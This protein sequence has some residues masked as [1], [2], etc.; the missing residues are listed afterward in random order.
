MNKSK[1][2]LLRE[3]RQKKISVEVALKNLQYPTQDRSLVDSDNLKASIVS[4]AANSHENT[5]DWQSYLRND[6]L[7]LVAKILKLKPEEIN[8][9]TSI[10]DLGL[11]SLSATEFNNLMQNQ[12]KIKISPTIFFECNTIDDFQSYLINRHSSQFQAYYQDEID[13]SVSPKIAE[14][15]F[16]KQSTATD[17]EQNHNFLSNK[18]SSYLE[19]IWAELE[20]NYSE[21]KTAKVGVDFARSHN[22]KRLVI[23][24]PD[25]LAIEV[26]VSSGRGEPL[27]LL[28]GL[29]NSEEIWSNQLEMLQENYQV[30]IFNKPGC[31]RS[32]INME[33]L[34]LDMI[35]HNILTVLDTLNIKSDLTVI[36]YSFGGILAQLLC[37]KYPQKV[38]SLIIACS[39]PYASKNRTE[40]SSLIEE[41]SNNQQFQEIFSN[42]DLKNL[43]PYYQI[44]N[45]FN[46]WADLE[47]ITVPTLILA[48]Q[49]D[50]YM[51]PVYSEAINQAIPQS[52]YQEIE[53]AGHLPLLTH[54]ANFNNKV[55]DFLSSLSAKKNFQ[56][57]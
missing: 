28:G 44:S 51:K 6:L 21:Q 29:L 26:F 16:T 2:D 36:G 30:I 32:E 48:G 13:S 55:S 7:N 3:V 53:G 14:P 19:N 33:T 38:K 1:I 25:G 15:N 8:P 23:Y 24:P 20:Q 45:G 18:S 54:S 41:L 9:S 4:N 40:L 31:G 27:L 39:T 50:R 12:Y 42:V 52:Q 56:L 34:T 10:A 49:K 11:D 22:I 17:V 57:D 43:R 47:K 46:V 5:V 35:V 37:L